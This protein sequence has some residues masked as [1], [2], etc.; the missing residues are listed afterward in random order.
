MKSYQFLLFFS[1]VFIVYAAVNS[2]IFIRA[3]Q[4]IPAGHAF[5]LW[6]KWGFWILA[7]SYLAGR[8]L[9]KVWLSGF[10]DVVTWTGALWLGIMLYG[11]LA[12]LLIDVLR[13]ADGL[14]GFLPGWVYAPE[15]RFKLFGWVSA[16]LI[17]IVA[18]GHINTRFPAIKTL[19]IEIGKP[20]GRFSELKIAMASDVHM[21]TLVG[22]ARTG[23]L[24]QTINGMNPDIILFAGDIVDED[25]AP[26]IRGN[27]GDALA[28]LNAPL[29]VYGVTGNHEY[30]GGAGKAVAYLEEHGVKILRDSVVDV[31]GA[32]YVAGR[33]DR[34]KGR[35]SG[36]SRK[37]VA[38]LLA[39][40][41]KNR[42]V[43]LIDHQPWDLPL[44]ARAGADLQLSGHTHHG[45][46]WP[47]N[48]ITRA[49][50]E[51]SRGYKKIDNTHFYVS[52]GYGSWGPPVR[53]GHRPE[54]VL[55]KVKFKK[56][57][58]E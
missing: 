44:A 3:H 55:I 24:V 48:Y 40:T 54:V 31:E 23:R 57:T 35:F 47:L 15:F 43:I 29:G 16:V 39:N 5:R 13:G 20:A 49:I 14:A 56:A 1:I 21:G 9:E 36:K 53:T 11:F 17:M 46:L 27:L 34:D 22:P 8:F 4:A 50:Y 18:A 41:D 12:V 32:F 10:S 19:E 30:I 38:D 33:E 6:F 58:T 42:P 45:Q 2:Y 26:V 52:T 7:L 37:E 51:V 25:L 28:Q